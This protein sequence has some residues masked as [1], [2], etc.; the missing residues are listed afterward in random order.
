[1]PAIE[2]YALIGAGNTLLLENRNGSID[3]LCAPYPHSAA[4]C[5]ALLGTREHGYWQMR[6]DGQVETTRRYTDAGMGVETTW[7]TDNGVAKLHTHIRV[8][9]GSAVLERSIEC[10]KGECHVSSIFHP[11][12]GYGSTPAQITT[13]ENGSY[14]LSF[15][16]GLTTDFTAPKATQCNEGALETHVRLTAGEKASWVLSWQCDS[17]Q[18]DIPVSAVG[19][20]MNS[21][22]PTRWAQMVSRSVQVLTQLCQP[23]GAILAAP[24]TSLPE[25]FGGVRNWDYRYCW[26]RDSALTVE[27]LLI[28]RHWGFDCT[29]Y[30]IRWREWITTQ[31]LNDP[32]NILIMYGINGERELEEK[33]LAHLPGFAHSR[34]V[35]IGNG[36]WNQYQADVAGEVLLCFAQLRHAGIMDTPQSWLA[37]KY[38]A[39]FMC[40]HFDRPDHGIWEMR[41][42][43]QHFTHSRAMMWA[44]FNQLLHAVSAYPDTPSEQ[45]HQWELFRDRLEEE[46]LT[47]GVHPTHGYFTQTFG[48][49]EVDASLLQLPHTGLIA[50]DDP[51]MRATIER[52]EQELGD[53]NGFICRY[54]TQV[55]QAGIDGIAGGE[56]PFVICNFWLAEAYAHSGEMMKAQALVDRLCD[57]AND[58]GLLAEEYDP[59]TQRLAGNFPQAFSHV[60]LIRAVAACAINMGE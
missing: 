15:A 42:Q 44:G 17:A 43:L 30:A 5:A 10:M 21:Q 35:R 50:W 29:D 45:I 59:E 36:A 40:A 19:Q 34:P 8:E 4:I 55:D 32:E 14:Q 41:G 33:E 31:I 9:S 23:S 28:A 37:Q 25:F 56:Y 22:V 24:T 60:G 6:V 49:E 47:F 11:L 12:G 52:I 38:L 57:C 48:G 53:D 51:R 18:S 2:D 16:E 46:I 58:L 54:H 26:L 1:M 39:D 13:R 3:W 7:I 27:A 20:A